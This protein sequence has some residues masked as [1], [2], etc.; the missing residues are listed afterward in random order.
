M[1]K[2]EKVCKEFL[3]GCGNL[4]KM[5][6]IYIQ[7]GNLIRDCEVKVAYQ[8]KLINIPCTHIRYS[9]NPGEFAYIEFIALSL[10]NQVVEEI[11]TKTIINSYSDST[12]IPPKYELNRR[13]IGIS[14][15][16][17]ANKIINISYRNHKG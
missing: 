12:I 3:K 5:P 9:I 8:D 1:N 10:S 14:Y 15:K 13:H 2:Y 4:E 16:I 7:L 6:D 11:M 17:P